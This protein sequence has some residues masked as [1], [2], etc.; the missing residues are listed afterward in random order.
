[1]GGLVSWERGKGV[2]VFGGENRKGD[3]NI[4]NVN[5]QIIY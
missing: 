5:K 3:D 2:G 4:W 1:V